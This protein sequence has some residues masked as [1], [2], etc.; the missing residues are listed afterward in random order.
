MRTLCGHASAQ[1]GHILPGH[2]YSGGAT[3]ITDFFTGTTSEFWCPTGADATLFQS[4]GGTGAVTNGDPVGYVGS[5]GGGV[6]LIQSTAAARP[7]WDESLGLLALNGTSQFLSA[8]LP[9]RSTDMYFAMVIN[10]LDSAF[11][12]AVSPNTGFFFGVCANGNT[13]T[14]LYA[15]VGTPTIYINGSVFSGTTRDNLRD[16]LATGSANIVEFVGLD[17][18]NAN[19]AT[20]K[21]THDADLMSGRYGDFV[22]MANPGSARGQIYQI[23]A[24]RHA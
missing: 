9:S 20:M 10:T 21:I 1:S 16:A 5:E 7:T 19:W 6:N 12:L 18:S 8:S 14:T 24:A 22:L 15:N 13:N 11:T 23:L 4:S 2:W 17:L 3:L